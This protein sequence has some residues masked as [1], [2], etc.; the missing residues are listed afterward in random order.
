MFKYF[1]EL[2]E[3]NLLTRDELPIMAN[4]KKEKRA[5]TKNQSTE[6]QKKEY[7]IIVDED[8]RT[9]QVA[10]KIL[11]KITWKSEIGQKEEWII[12]REWKLGLKTSFIVQQVLTSIT[13]AQKGEEL[14]EQ[15]EYLITRTSIQDNYDEDNEDDE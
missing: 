8:R 5:E 1:A 13:A 11:Q 4:T 15:K 7:R 6:P 14:P 2:H 9:H 12:A 10:Y 3:K